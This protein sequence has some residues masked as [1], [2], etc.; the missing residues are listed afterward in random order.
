M[1]DEEWFL[2]LPRRV[3]GRTAAGDDAP[4]GGGAAGALGTLLVLTEA[5]LGRAASP[6]GI[7]LVPGDCP[8]E[9]LERVP[10]ETVVTYGMSP[11]DSLTFSSLEGPVLCVQRRLPRLDGTVVE[12][13]EVPLPG[14]SGPP[15]LLLP[16]LG[17]RVLQMPLPVT[18]AL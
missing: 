1:W 6:C 17:A 18:W 10:A 3:G 12:P 9:L 14:L 16:V 8:A 2:Y 11:R 7:L 15:E 4:S 5:G 13:Q